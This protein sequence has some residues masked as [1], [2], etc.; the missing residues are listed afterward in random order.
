ATELHPDRRR[1]D[2]RL[3]PQPTSVIRRS[4]QG[5]CCWPTAPPRSD[6]RL[7]SPGQGGRRH[8]FVVIFTR[9]ETPLRCYGASRQRGGPNVRD[10][11]VP[12]EQRV[13][14]VAAP[15]EGTYRFSI[16]GKSSRQIT[17]VTCN[18]VQAVS[19][20]CPRTS[21]SRAR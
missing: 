20:R 15:G 7:A 17:A 13:V 11:R 21:S 10:R 12:E 5:F 14:V 9:G 18:C 1:R 6:G 19:M 3:R 4:A 8:L 2:D 16:S